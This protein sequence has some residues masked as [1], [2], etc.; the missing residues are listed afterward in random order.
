[1]RVVDDHQYGRLVGRGGQQAEGRRRD[2]EAVS[3]CRRPERERAPQGGRLWWRDAV[4]QVPNRPHEIEQPRER[5]IGF[6]LE[7]PG[8]KQ[9]EFAV[10]L[11]RDL[12]EQAGLADPRL[13]VDDERRAH[14]LARGRA[15]EETDS[16]DLDGASEEHS[17]NL[18]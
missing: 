17:R 9:L 15:Q 5:K 11:R 16:P 1:M 12:V 18:S 7:W 2:R 13:A 3:G 8:A 6:G 10:R 14:A 4:E